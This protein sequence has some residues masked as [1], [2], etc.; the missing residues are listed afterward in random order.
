LREDRVSK[1]LDV[2]SLVMTAA[3][4]KSDRST[5]K[6]ALDRIVEVMARHPREYEQQKLSIEDMHLLGKENDEDLA[7]RMERLVKFSKIF[8]MDDDYFLRAYAESGPADKF[9]LASLAANQ[10]RRDILSVNPEMSIVTSAG[11]SHVNTDAISMISVRDSRG[12]S[13]VRE[14]L[15]LA[16]AGQ[17]KNSRPVM[18]KAGEA[19]LG[20]DDKDLMSLSLKSRSFLPY[21]AMASLASSGIREDLVDAMRSA[22]VSGD[23]HKATR[24]L[25][26]A[27][28]AKNFPGDRELVSMAFRVLGAVP[29]DIGRVAGRCL[30]IPYMQGARVDWDGNM[31]PSPAKI[32]SLG[33]DPMS[34]A[35]S[36]RILASTGD[37]EAIAGLRRMFHLA[38]Q[39]GQGDRTPEMSHLLKFLKES[40]SEVGDSDGILDALDPDP[41]MPAMEAQALPNGSILVKRGSVFKVDDDIIFASD[42]DDAVLVAVAELSRQGK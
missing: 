14:A 41:R 8:A 17:V 12:L 13:V 26:A 22:N 19:L 38:S 24:S 27:S 32:Y 42:P 34:L 10:D 40:L 37:E 7:G 11:G 4:Y 39:A 9:M 16:N 6:R 31:V 23:V 36:Y 20:S 28:I 3:S 2:A 21:L 33:D 15:A 25:V 35:K 5:K 18:E 30:A 29:A 1:S